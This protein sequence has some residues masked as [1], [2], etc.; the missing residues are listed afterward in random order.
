[1][2]TVGNT[3]Q[4]WVGL[5]RYLVAEASVM[6]SIDLDV[7]TLADRIEGCSGIERILV[8]SMGGGV[9]AAGPC[10]CDHPLSLKG[11]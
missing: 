6:F 11:C 1:M 10:E 7:E 5:S 3:R 2:S 8:A 4:I 9:V